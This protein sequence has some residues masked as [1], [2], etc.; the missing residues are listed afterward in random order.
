MTGYGVG[1]A[2]L[3]QGR[4]IVEVRSLNHRF[5]EVRVR[6]PGEIS[7]HA[8]FVEQACRERFKRGRYDVSVRLEGSALPPT[9][10]DLDAARHTYKE[11]CALRDELS[12]DSEVP[13][14][15][16]AHIPALFTSSASSDPGP[17][18]QAL[19]S[20][21]QE[22]S[23]RLNEMRG[24]EGQALKQELGLRLSAAR[25]A[26]AEIAAR[27]PE[28]VEAY[29]ERLRER[30]ERLGSEAEIQLDAGRLEVEVAILADKSDIAE[31]LAR[32]ESHFEQFEALTSDE[33]P[34][35]RRMDFLLQ[36]ISREANTIGAK[37]HDVTLSHSVVQLK[38]EVERLREQV[39]NV[40]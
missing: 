2:Q 13:I 11:L 9:S 1:G 30:V 38:A 39:Q 23:T 28:L 16:V 4:V 24:K 21:L 8:F 5:V 22:A 32:L 14:S 33:H 17:V 40:E 37:S 34:V 10:L 35:G 18:R 7:D 25:S 15:A 29:R 6:M 12:P 31:E 26:T 19:L 36:E 20:A 3:G 27:A